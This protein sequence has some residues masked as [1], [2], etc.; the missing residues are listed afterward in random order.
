MIKAGDFYKARPTPTTNERFN[1][2]RVV[3]TDPEHTHGSIEPKEIVG[4]RHGSVVAFSKLGFIGRVT[5]PI[6][7]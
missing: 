3:S 2:C 4:R 6:M 7:S 1:E 5:G